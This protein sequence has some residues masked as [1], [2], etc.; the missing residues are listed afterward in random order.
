MSES[1]S[2]LKYITCILILLTI[3]AMCLTTINR[4]KNNIKYLKENGSKTVGEVLNVTGKNMTWVYDCGQKEIFKKG[5]IPHQGIR[6]G[7][8]YSVY[9]DKNNVKNAFLNSFE[10]RIDTMDYLTSCS[11]D[12]KIYDSDKFSYVRYTVEVNSKQYIRY[13]NVILPESNIDA[14]NS[15]RVFYNKDNPSICYIDLKNKCG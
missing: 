1:N 12:L 11:G 7:E 10:P 6:V 9:F 4:S 15:Y 5:S 2:K 8:K 13:Q 14:N 3:P